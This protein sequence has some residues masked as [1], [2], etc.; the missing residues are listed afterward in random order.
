VIF[1]DQ[2]QGLVTGDKYEYKIDVTDEAVPIRVILVYTDYPGANLVNNLNLI[3]Y[4]PSGKYHVGNHR[5]HGV[6]DFTK[7]L[8]NANNVEGIVIESPETG[9][10]KIVVLASDVSEE[11]QDFAIVASGGELELVDTCHCTA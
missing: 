10:W 2:R 7:L 1:E 6:D 4:S 5:E 9:L 3:L 11:T 8:D